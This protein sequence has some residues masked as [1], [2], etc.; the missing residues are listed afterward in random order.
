MRMTAVLVETRGTLSSS[1]LS[2]SEL[3]RLIDEEQAVGVSRHVEGARRW[4]EVFQ[5]AWYQ[6][7]G[8]SRKVQRW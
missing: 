4:L 3:A 6:M 2:P 7:C 8:R 5:S 1:R